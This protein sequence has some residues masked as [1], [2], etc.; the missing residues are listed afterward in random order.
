MEV[1]AIVLSVPAAFICSIVYSLI[2]GRLTRGMDRAKRIV[3]W[4]S[5]IVLGV[6]GLEAFGVATIGAPALRESIGV[7]YYPLHLALF[8]CSVPSLA[9]VLVLQRKAT[10]LSRWYAIGTMCAIVG[11]GVVLLQYS[12]SE[13]LYGVDGG[14]GPYGK[15]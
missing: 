15:P 9:N 13:A 5:A 2:I 4:S 8:L 12:V 11:L 14:G 3:M 7:S 6:S 10:H 1:L